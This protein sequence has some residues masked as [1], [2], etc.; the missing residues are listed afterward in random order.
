LY[1][2][3]VD[4]WRELLD[5]EL[6]QGLSSRDFYKLAA[7]NGLDLPPSAIG[8]IKRVL[9]TAERALR[10]RGLGEEILIDPLWRRLEDGMNPGQRAR[11]KREA[12]GFEEFLDSITITMVGQGHPAAVG[13]STDAPSRPDIEL[14]ARG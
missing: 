3:L 12:E 1:L 7:R 14:G 11:Q 8:F 13:E 5:Q 6:P 9:H 2:G 4:G 10:R